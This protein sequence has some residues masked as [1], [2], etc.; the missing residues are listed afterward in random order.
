VLID[1]T[2]LVEGENEV[3]GKGPV[4]EGCRFPNHGAG[5]IGPAQS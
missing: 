2:V 4:R 3:A 5:V 1:S